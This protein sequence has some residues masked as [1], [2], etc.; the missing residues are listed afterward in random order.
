MLRPYSITH[1]RRI[2]FCDLQDPLETVDSRTLFRALFL[3]YRDFGYYTCRSSIT[4]S[5]LTARFCEI[6]W[7]EVLMLI[8]VHKTI[9]QEKM[10]NTGL[11][12]EQVF[13]C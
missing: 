4:S 12:R 5:D 2:I 11:W 9:I 10:A 3:D 13:T 1:S 6:S 8:G 7:L